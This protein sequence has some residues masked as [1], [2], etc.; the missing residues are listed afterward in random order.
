MN[1]KR[2]LNLIV[3]MYYI[4]RGNL[5]T[6]KIVSEFDRIAWQRGIEIKRRFPN[7]NNYFHFKLK[8]FRLLFFF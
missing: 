3:C 6:N 8:I 4:G 7:R 5:S 2:F 1:R